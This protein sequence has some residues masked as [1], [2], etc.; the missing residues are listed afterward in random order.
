MGLQL[1]CQRSAQITEAFRAIRKELGEPEVLVYNAGT[2][3]FGSITEITPEQYEADWRVNAFG[4]FVAAKEVAPGM[5]ERGH[6]TMLFTGATAGVKAGAKSVSFG[7]AKFAMRGLAQSLARDLVRGYPRGVDQRRR[8]YRHPG[9]AR[10]EAQP[11]RRRLSQ[12]RGDRRDLLASRASGS[13]RMD[14]G[15]R[16][17]SLQGEILINDAITAEMARINGERRAV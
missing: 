12:A 1:R 3:K 17:P 16:S 9:S 6:G 10:A 5:I 15:T 14:D 7:P 13:E 4:A 11:E 8:Q 2:G